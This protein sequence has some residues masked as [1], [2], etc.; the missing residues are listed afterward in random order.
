MN[1]RVP[2]KAQALKH[3]TQPRTLQN[4]RSLVTTAHTWFNVSYGESNHGTVTAISGTTEGE[5]QGDE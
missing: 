1:H 3:H 5:Q 2:A 4:P